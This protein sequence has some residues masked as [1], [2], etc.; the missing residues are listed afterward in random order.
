MAS[1]PPPKDFDHD[2]ADAAGTMTKPRP[3]SV[4]SSANGEDAHIPAGNFLVQRHGGSHPMK[5]LSSI[6]VAG[7]LAVGTVAATAGSA[8]ADWHPNGPYHQHHAHFPG[9][10]GPGWS[11][12]GG[13]GSPNWG[14]G[15]DGYQRG[16]GDGGALVAARI[17]GLAAGLVASEALEPQPQP[18]YAYPP[19]PIA[20]GQDEHAAWCAGTYKS[21]DYRY[22]TWRDF[23][24]VVHPC[25]GPY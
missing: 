22:D 2:C 8:S 3:F 6:V 5:I 11:G 16:G 12:G 25:V 20:Y 15:G 4:R 13:G 14:G 18:Y 23:E 17:F 7:A 24:G 1:H 9:G 10:G 19:A 21:Y